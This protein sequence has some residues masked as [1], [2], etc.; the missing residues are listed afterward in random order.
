MD[1]NAK[2]MQILDDLKDVA[3]TRARVYSGAAV[4]NLESIRPMLNDAIDQ[5]RS[6]LP[7]HNVAAI[8]GAL[9]EAARVALLAREA[10]DLERDIDRHLAKVAQ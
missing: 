5:A 6:G 7:I 2:A 4:A 3:Q 9:R 8:D 1:A 10:R